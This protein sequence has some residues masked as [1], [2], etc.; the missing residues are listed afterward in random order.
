MK[1]LEREGALVVLEGAFEEAAEGRG[2]VALVTGEAGIGKTSLVSLFV[3]RREGRGRVLW[4]I[5]DDLN[6]PRPLGPIRDL[7]GVSGELV[8]ALQSA[9]APARVHGLVLEELGGLPRPTVLVL[10]DVHWA[11]EATLD[12]VT[13]VG[14][15]IA[16]LPALLV[17]T[18]RDGELTSDHP[19]R[20]R[21]GSLPAH[22]TVHLALKPLTP[23]AVAA[24][25][26]PD[27]EEIF[28]MTRGNPFFV[29]ELLAAR[30]DRLPPSVALAV[31][32]RAARLEEPS[33]RLLELASVVPARVDT[34]LLDRVFPE[35]PAAAEEPE[36]RGLLV[37]DS[38]HLAFRHELARTAI[39]AS[40][41]VARRRLLS[42]Q[43]LEALLQG[44][45][46]PSD[47]VH[48]AEAAG[49]TDVIARYAVVAARNSRHASANREAWSHYVRAADFADGMSLA[50][51][52]AFLEEMSLAAYS[53]NRSVDALEAIDKA[54]AVHTEQGDSIGV[55]RSRRIKSRLCWYSG[56]GEGASRAGRAAVD[57]LEPY[58]ESRELAMAY[59]NLSQLAM[60]SDRNAEALDW[61]RRAVGMA[62]RLGD[63]ATRAHALVNIGTM[64]VNRDPDERATLLD[65][66][67]V[68]KAVAARHEAGR[69]LQ[70]LAFAQ[71]FW[72]R[73]E[74][75][76]R[77]VGDAIEYAAAHEQHTLLSYSRVL[78]AWLRL[79]G[80]EWDEAERIAQGEAGSTVTVSHLFATTVLAYLAVRR[81][82]ADAD[83]RLA[84]ARLQAERLGEIQRTILVLAAEVELALTRGRPIPV[85]SVAATLAG[86]DELS[87]SWVMGFGAA[88]AALAGVE[89]ESDAPM[90]PPQAAMHR[91]DWRAAADAWA[92]AGWYF[93]RALCLSMLDDEAALAEAIEIAREM[94]A[95]PLEERVA[96][97]MK[98]H[99]YPVP[100]RRRETTRANPAGLTERQ[101]EVLGLVAG[102]LT[103][104]EIADELY[105]SPR[106]VDHHVAAILTKLEV[107]TRRQAAE[108]ARRLGLT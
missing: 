3:A 104:A 18:Y 87:Q 27:G 42:G 2:R 23:Q 48:H 32:A 59:S 37:V 43:V 69:A 1:L 38:R 10:E 99:G 15:R 50:E 102:G 96:S 30:P 74:E 47:I 54:I 49:R 71:T 64:E 88:V 35:W 39:A 65:G 78:Q 58:G 73:A 6:I 44:D 105:L 46:D 51:R 29:T 66:Y 68:G 92:A 62:E 82:D 98:G 70:N 17:L 26:G 8:E 93:E 4:G 91:R 28:G 36:R 41:P 52:G 56:D 53:V 100:R 61:G 16:D 84:S 34:W 21:I 12:L 107:A 95:R 5:C 97:R 45:A 33:R 40:L 101:V 31:V 75:A 63:D 90:A 24:L 86:L 85:D 79:L 94:G 106:T 22:A 7:T 103:N 13:V 89:H 25:A 67:R 80:G 83:E 11:D 108:H 60:L 20:S 76:E 57:I 77:C 19:L 72:L 9:A 55:G 81:G 14:R